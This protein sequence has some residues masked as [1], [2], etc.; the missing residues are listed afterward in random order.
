MGSNILF[1]WWYMF[2]LWRIY[3]HLELKKM[4]CITGPTYSHTAD[5]SPGINTNNRG[6]VVEVQLPAASQTSAHLSHTP[7]CLPTNKDTTPHCCRA[8]DSELS[9]ML[10]AS[11]WPYI[12]P[13]HYHK[14]KSLTSPGQSLN[15]CCRLHILMIQILPGLARV[16]RLLWVK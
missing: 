2:E 9:I 1:Q 11:F 8:L 16:L 4:G 10:R 7:I 6:Q 15:I 12:R 13:A 3:A 5:T 14:L